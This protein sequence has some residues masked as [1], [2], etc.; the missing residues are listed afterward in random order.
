MERQPS[1]WSAG[2]GMG[3]HRETST[4]CVINQNT[5]QKRLKEEGFVLDYAFCV[6][7]YIMTDIVVWSVRAEVC[8]LFT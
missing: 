5:Q 6:C 7:D 2:V 4:S 8:G 1:E 3:R